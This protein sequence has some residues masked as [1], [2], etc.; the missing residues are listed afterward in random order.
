MEQT[1]PRLGRGLDALLGAVNGGGVLGIGA[2]VGRVRLD[3]IHHN[4][5]QPR[6]RFD[7][8][9][10]KQLA[11]SIRVHGVLQPLVVRQAGDDYQL[12]A[13]ERRLR[14]AT[15]AGLPEVPVHVVGFDDQQVY[16]AAL[17]ENI[18]RQELNPIEEATAYWQRTDL[19]PRPHDE[20]DF[21]ALAPHLGA[22]QRDWLRETI[23]AVIPG[24]P[25]LARLE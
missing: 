8:D 3:Q 6:K 1:K 2:S 19:K 23:H 11:D 24:H 18:Q 9:E 25:W 12:I 21:E 17:V 4:P 22:G 20:R 10:L 7:D 15:L 13:G 16:E 14:A 5:Y